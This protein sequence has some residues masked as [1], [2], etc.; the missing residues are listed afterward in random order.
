[1]QHLEK[2][3]KL[4]LVNLFDL[5]LHKLTQKLTAA[6][7]KYL[8]L[9]IVTCHYSFDGFRGEDIQ[10]FIVGRITPS[11]FEIPATQPLVEQR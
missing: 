2:G 7:R 6:E 11:N 4:F 1:M 10:R 3:A 9:V 8:D 5:I